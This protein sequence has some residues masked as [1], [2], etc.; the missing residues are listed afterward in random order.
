[1]TDLKLCH[2]CGRVLPVEDFPVREGYRCS[3]CRQCEAQRVADWRVTH[4]DHL[5]EYRRATW[6]ANR[7]QM[8]EDRK[9]RALDAVM[10]RGRE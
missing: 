7:A 8:L 10:T 1:M 6:R 2:K 9:R 4:A 3:P 5:R